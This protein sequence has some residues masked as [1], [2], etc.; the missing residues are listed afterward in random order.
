[1]SFKFHH[2]ELV[3]LI[4]MKAKKYEEKISLSGYTTFDTEGGGGGGGSRLTLNHPP[5][6]NL[7]CVGILV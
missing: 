4:V 7:D 6:E 2:L 1:M 3:I 5:G